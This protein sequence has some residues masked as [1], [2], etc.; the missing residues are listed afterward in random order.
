M[1]NILFLLSSLLSVTAIATSTLWLAVAATLLAVLGFLC[2]FG[3]LQ[4]WIVAYAM[5]RPYFHLGD[6]QQRYWLLPFWCLKPNPVEGGFLPR[7]WV[8]IRPRVHIYGRGDK[9]PHLHD[10]PADNITWVLHGEFWEQIPISAEPS[11]DFKDSNRPEATREKFRGT[12]DVVFRLAGSRHKI[13]ISQF[14][15]EPLVTLFIFGPKRRDWGFT[16]PNGWVFWRDYLDDQE[17]T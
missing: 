9:E 8:L 5:P 15:K 16:T 13:V 14:V 6:Y 3:V 11:W 17:S 12:D 10:H 1:T 4:R 2:L 7:R